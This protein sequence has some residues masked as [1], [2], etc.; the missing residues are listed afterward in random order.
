[1]LFQHLHCI[2]VT[3]SDV[4]QPL[5]FDLQ[6][7]IAYTGPMHLDAEIICVRMP[8]CDGRQGSTITKTD[9]QDTWRRTTKQPIKVQSALRQGGLG[10]LAHYVDASFGD[11]QVTGPDIDSVEPGGAM[12]LA[13]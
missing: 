9:F 8:G 5:L 12:P 6:Q 13:C 2:I 1:M 3:D 4:P 10:L 7:K 11:V